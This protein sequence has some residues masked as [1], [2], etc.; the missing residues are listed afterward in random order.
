MA[1]N[2]YYEGEPDIGD[3]LV[4]YARELDQNPQK[5]LE[6]LDDELTALYIRLDND[7]TGRGVLGDT[8][9][10]NQI[11]ALQAVRA[12]CLRRLRENS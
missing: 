11:A 7:Q 1:I 4:F 3:A 6:E 5:L 10:L 8:R 9:Q 2:W 12:E